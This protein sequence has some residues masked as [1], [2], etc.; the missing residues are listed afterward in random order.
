MSKSQ[1]PSLFEPELLWHPFVLGNTQLNVNAESDADA[2]PL[3]EPDSEH[4]SNNQR[5][6][7]W[8]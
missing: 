7:Y 6:G 2:K 5:D 3:T 1:T 4:N 8:Q